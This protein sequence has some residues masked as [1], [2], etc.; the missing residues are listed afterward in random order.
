MNLNERIKPNTEFMIYHPS[1]L[2]SND[3][4]RLNH[5][6][7]PL[8]GSETMMTYLYFN[9]VRQNKDSL[10]ISLHHTLLDGLNTT[11]SA[12]QSSIEKLEA[13]G[14]LKTYKSSKAHDDLLIYELYVPMKSADFFDD[15]ILSF[16][17]HRQIGSDA[18]K[19]LLERFKY[20]SLPSDIVD[21]SKTFNEVF[22]TT[23]VERVSMTVPTQRY[24]RNSSG[25]NV[26]PDSFDF[27]VLFTHLKGTK[28][29]RQFFDKK[30]RLLITQLAVLFNLNAYDMKVILMDSTSTQYGIDARKLKQNARKYYQRENN[31]R[32]P[33]VTAN[34]T[35][36]EGESDSYFSRLEKI[37]PLDR[38]RTIR[39]HEPRDEDLKTITELLTRF[40]FTHGAIN[41]LMEYVYQQL[42]G[43]MPYSYVVKIANNWSESG[44]TNAEDALKEIQSF[45]T[46]QE[47]YR[48]KKVYSKKDRP[49]EVRPAWLEQKD[50]AKTTSSES[51]TNDIDETSDGEFEELL[52]YF[53]KGE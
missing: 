5:L 23:D 43:D 42:E 7:L 53:K 28:I 45:K 12:L 40:T 4:E 15:T 9:N 21:V 44:V 34:E 25:V 38:I 46:K 35:E 31:N 13:V 32:L 41:V 49:G 33:N 16:Y 24:Q 27:D 50:E 2:S 6:Y 10:S 26:D 36:T 37:N 1:E 39:Q 19:V 48:M 47:N 52:N 51:D 29:D 30:T 20:P 11:L 3:I 18:Y 17:L 8:V 14:L 22:D